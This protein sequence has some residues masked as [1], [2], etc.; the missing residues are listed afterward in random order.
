MATDS[1]SSPWEDIIRLGRVPIGV[2][3]HT[4][5]VTAK[6]CENPDCTCE[7]VA[8]YFRERQPSP[9][10]VAVAFDVG[11][12]LA[13][14]KPAVVEALGPEAKQI[15]AGVVAGLTGVTRALMRAEL[16]LKRSRLL[17]I[18][19]T[20]AE[21]A[22]RGETIP[23]SHVQAGGGPDDAETFG[24][25]ELF[26]HGAETWAV[27]DHYCGNLACG[28]NNVILAFQVAD[29]DGR[30]AGFDARLPIGKG[31][32]RFEDPTGMELAEARTVF[33]AWEAS[34]Q[35]TRANFG[36][37]YNRV[38]E[39]VRQQRSVARPPR[40]LGRREPCPCGSGKRY[41]NCCGQNRR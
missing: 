8:L 39:I 24:V 35:L 27:E 28:C 32:A 31:A 3:G 13:G 7:E 22:R 29:P 4:F 10:R 14:T 25:L 18:D 6:A 21:Y 23:W 5:D 30:P 33:G 1:D 16:V 17:L 12:D 41:K 9:P 40:P 38:R 20:V 2:G 15:A 34:T 37:R 11:L 26:T 19:S 36:V